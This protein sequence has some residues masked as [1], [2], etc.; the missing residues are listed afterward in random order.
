[1]NDHCA[2]GDQFIFCFLRQQA[3]FL[4]IRLKAVKDNLWEIWTEVI[5]KILELLL[6]EG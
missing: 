5:G 3:G 6:L 2:F 1:M 4:V